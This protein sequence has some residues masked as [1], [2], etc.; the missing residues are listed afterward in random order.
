VAGLFLAM[1]GIAPAQAGQVVGQITAVDAAQNTITIDGIRF[2]LS[3][4]AVKQA[5]ASSANTLLRRFRPG[6]SVLFEA[7]NNKLKRIEAV[8]GEV[9]FPVLLMPPSK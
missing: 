7:D 5:K 4:V 1:T 9:D 3:A 8:E 6:Q 2:E